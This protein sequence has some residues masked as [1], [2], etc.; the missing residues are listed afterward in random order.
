MRFLADECVDAGLIARLR[1]AG[2]DVQSIA[3]EYRG[4]SD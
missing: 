4:T 1:D 3:E 2:H